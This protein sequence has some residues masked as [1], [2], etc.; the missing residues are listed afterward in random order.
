[1]GVMVFTCVLRQWRL[2]K[3][4]SVECWNVDLLARQERSRSLCSHRVG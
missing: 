2:E 1:M 3:W 4:S